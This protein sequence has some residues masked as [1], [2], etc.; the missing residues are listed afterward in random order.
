MCPDAIHPVVDADCPNEV[1]GGVITGRRSQTQ[2]VTGATG[3]S[4][5]PLTIDGDLSDWGDLTH[6]LRLRWEARDAE[7]QIDSGIVP[8]DAPT[9]ASVT[10][11]LS[12]TGSSSPS[13]IRYTDTT[14]VSCTK[15]PSLGPAMSPRLLATRK[16]S[17]AISGSALAMLNG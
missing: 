7:N 4:P 13:S 15:N 17:S 2:R 9:K 10:A 1:V 8:T 6:P 5:M 12:S 14:R 11:E 16:L 3:N